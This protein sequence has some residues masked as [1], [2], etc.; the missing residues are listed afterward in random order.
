MVGFCLSGR[1]VQPV[2]LLRADGRVRVRAVGLPHRGSAAPLAGRAASS[3]SRTRV[4]ALLCSDRDRPALRAHGRAEHGADR[5]GARA[6]GRPDAL[7]SCVVRAPARRA[8][9]SRRR[10]CP[11]HFWL[12]DAYA[13]APDADLPAVRRGDERARAATRRADLLDGLRRRARRRTRR[14]CGRCWS[15]SACLTALRRGVMCLAQRHLKRMLAF[16]TVAHIG[17]VPDRH[18]AADAAGLARR[19]AS[20]SS[21][22][23]REG[24]AV[25]RRRDDRAP[26]RRAARSCSSSGAGG[27]HRSARGVLAAPAGLALAALP[28]FGPF[29]GFT[30]VG[31]AADAA[32]YGWARV[33]P[34]W[35]RGRSRE[36]RP[37]R[38]ADHV[39]DRRP[40][41]T[42]C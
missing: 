32:G 30:M 11:F 25:R 3:R 6:R 37:R 10:S 28:P 18:R 2:R 12:A 15:A 34:P 23:A 1:P 20:S 17:R 16:A 35:R 36:P 40:R 5:R 29:L 21:R 26:A 13:V 7:W 22:R 27:G 41:R 39:R 24:R 31:Q 9:S 4:G 42:R 33:S 38:A 14:R 8:S 19:R